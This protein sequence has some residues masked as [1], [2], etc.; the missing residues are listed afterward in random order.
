MPKYSASRCM[1]T[2]DYPVTTDNDRCQT[3]EGD[4]DRKLIFDDNFWLYTDSETGEHFTWHMHIYVYQYTTTNIYRVDYDMINT[5]DDCHEYNIDFEISAEDEILAKI[6]DNSART[7]DALWGLIDSFN[8]SLGD[9]DPE[10]W[11]LSEFEKL[12]NI[13][14]NKQ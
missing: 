6:S 3:D 7:M 13:I 10:V 14:N 5:K 2:T 8:H 9:R 4:H 11:A 1:R 12:C